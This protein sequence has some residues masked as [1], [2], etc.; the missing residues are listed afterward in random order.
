[1]RSRKGLHSTPLAGHCHLMPA[2]SY[3]QAKAHKQA[4][5]VPQAEPGVED[6]ADLYSDADD[7]DTAT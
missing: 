6:D 1:M 4:A 3:V 5:F 7:M 2:V